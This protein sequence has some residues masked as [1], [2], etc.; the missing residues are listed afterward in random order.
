MLQC[1]DGHGK[2]SPHQAV[3]EPIAHVPHPANITSLGF[4]ALCT[5][6]YPSVTEQQQALILRKC[7]LDSSDHTNQQTYVY[8]RLGQSWY[9]IY[10]TEVFD[11]DNLPKV[12]QFALVLWTK[13]FNPE[14][15]ETLCRILSKTYCKTG[16]PVAML[17]LYLSVATRGVCTTEENGTF[18][19]RDFDSSKN[20][21]NTHVKELLNT[22]GLESILIYTALLLKKRIIVYHHSLDA[23]LK[24]VRSFPAFMLHRKGWDCLFPWTDLYPNEV[25]D[26]KSNTSY[27]AGCREAIIESRS[28]LYDVLV[29]LPARE[30]TIAPHAKES[31]VMT[32]SHKE[33]ALF[34][35]QLSENTSLGEQ[36]IIRAIADKTAD[37]LAQLRS[38]A[39]TQ[40]SEGKAMVSIETL[41]GRALTPALENFLFNLAVAEN[42]MML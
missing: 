2:P 18:L 41:R 7:G 35:V 1:N 8:S 38:L 15:Y 34:L 39:T 12:K 13:D 29:H 32:K 25:L 5:W 10:F 24:A 4:D 16:N 36:Q 3:C 42:M 37:L 31:M 6:T 22:F 20:F 33:I 40:T 23:L 26:L 28:D 9:Y 14:K 17:T 11:S 19:A 30:I 21:T 27:I